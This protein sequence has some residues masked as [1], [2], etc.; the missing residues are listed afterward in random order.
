MTD[1]QNPYA[2]DNDAASAQAGPQSPF[3]YAQAPQQHAPAQPGFAPAGQPRASIGDAFGPGRNVLGLVSLGSA[4][5][6]LV[7][8]LLIGLLSVFLLRP[9]FGVFQLL[10]GANAVLSLILM[11]VAVGC[12]IAGLLARNPSKWPAIAGL[13]IG[14]YSLISIIFTAIF[15][16]MYSIF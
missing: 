14:V 15:G 11:L 12:G 4:A 13:A 1:S 7:L 5:I 6:A 16:A 3:N 10:N 9:N 8:S 2:P